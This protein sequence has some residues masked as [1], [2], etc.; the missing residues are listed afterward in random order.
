MLL[1]FF[2]GNVGV[3]V[4]EIILRSKNIRH[5]LFSGRAEFAHDNPATGRAIGGAV[6]FALITI[7]RSNI[8]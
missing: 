3:I 6:R 8:L 2:E 4:A 7:A 5:L 1:W